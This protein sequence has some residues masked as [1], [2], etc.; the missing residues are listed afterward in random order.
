MVINRNG[1]ILMQINNNYFVRSFHFD[2]QALAAESQKYA[3]Q[4]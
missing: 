2:Q 4:Y 1:N 3:V